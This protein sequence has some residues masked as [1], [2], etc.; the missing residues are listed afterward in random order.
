MPGAPAAGTA[1]PVVLHIEDNPA[2]RRLMQQIF[3]LRKDL[4][5]READSA[6]SGLDLAR[7]VAPALILMDINLPG[8]DGFAALEVI[9]RDP[10][11]AHIPVIAISANAM[12]GDR[13]RGLESGF[14]DY[15]TKPLDVPW[16]LGRLDDLLAGK[17]KP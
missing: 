16:F 6:E 8:M 10:R 9:Q 4:A 17:G 11:T 7:R 2:N 13:E 12:K 15:L 14:V 5:L 3:R 1:Q